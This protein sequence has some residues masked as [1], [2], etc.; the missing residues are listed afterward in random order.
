MQ[1][2]VW[3]TPAVWCYIDSGGLMFSSTMQCDVRLTRRKWLTGTMRCLADAY[4]LTF[5]HRKHIPLLVNRNLPTLSHVPYC[6]HITLDRSLAN[7][8]YVPA[9]VFL[10]PNNVP[11]TQGGRKTPP[12]NKRGPFHIVSMEP[13]PFHAML[14]RQCH[15][16]SG[17]YMYAVFWPFPAVWRHQPVNAA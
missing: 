4:R 3:L 13:W 7:H 10:S 11:G 1:N 14:L 6:V 16:S 15:V 8:V 9:E 5:Q 2:Y 12:S 17:V